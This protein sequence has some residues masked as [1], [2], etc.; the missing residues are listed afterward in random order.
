M[1]FLVVIF[2]ILLVTVFQTS[3][4]SLCDERDVIHVLARGSR[5]AIH[6]IY[7]SHGPPSLLVARTDTVTRL[8][9]NCSLF[10]DANS[11]VESDSIR[12][13]GP[14][15]EVMVLVFTRVCWH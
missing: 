9:F 3:H 15:D 13:S 2:L 6:Y 8:Q 12:F 5:D 4:E 11:S 7:S 1:E 14:A 10:H